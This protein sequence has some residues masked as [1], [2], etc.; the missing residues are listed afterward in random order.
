[1]KPY[2]LHVFILSFLLVPFLSTAQSSETVLIQSVRFFDG[3]SV[4]ERMDVFF[5][6]SQIARIV[7]HSPD[8]RAKEIIDGRGKT[9]IPALINAH[10]HIWFPLHLQEAARAGVLTVMDMHSSS[11]SLPILKAFQDST[12]Y[13]NYLSAGPGATVPGGHGTQFGMPTPTIDSTTSAQ[14]FT[15]DRVEG[16]SDYIK[17]L[18]EPSRPTINFAQIDTVI[19]TAHERAKLAVAH[20]SRKKD[21]IRLATSNLDGFVHIWFDEVSTVEEVDTIAKGKVF[22]VPTIITNKRVLDYFES[23]GRTNKSLT[24]EELKAEVKK[25]HEAGVILVAG[26]DPPNF[27][28]NYGTDLLTEIELFVECGLSPLEA[29]RSATGNA[30]KSFQLKEAGQLRENGPAN[31]L[32]IQG[33]P[34]EDIKAIR[35]IEKVWKNGQLV[36]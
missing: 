31:A 6:G 19:A 20:I 4:Q 8:H 27:N 25:L 33:N 30:A 2:V 34:M 26:T 24:F 14:V 12:N 9:L 13:A 18:R 5:E 10:V 11:Y 15:L 22:M 7:P 35:N 36:K 29:L 1:M 23:Q 17:I 3:E 21:A 32:L 28:I 16:G